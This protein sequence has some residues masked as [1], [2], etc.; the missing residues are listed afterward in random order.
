MIESSPSDGVRPSNTFLASLGPEAT[1]RL[2]AAGRRI[3]APP[4]H[5]PVAQGL[6]GRAVY[7]PD[8]GLI[9]ELWSSPDGRVAETAVVGSDGAVGFVEAMADAPIRC[10]HRALIGGG[11]WLV[12]ASAVQE[13]ISQDRRAAET[14]WSHME[15]LRREARQGSACR[16]LHPVQTRLADTLLNYAERIGADR[17]TITHEVLGWSLGVCRTTVTMLMRE[18]IARE[19]VDPGRGRLTLLD[20]EGLEAMACGCRRL[21][22]ATPRAA[23]VS[24]TADRTAQP[25][26]FVLE[27]SRP[28]P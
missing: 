15:R 1:R 16:A 9:S 17:L 12:R 21:A 13:L 18:L 23:Q 28:Q 24:S 22:G 25:N 3:A 26:G 20:T 5:S 4:G 27:P 14:A 6:D 8:S 2:L 19:L 10:Q 7:F 11:G